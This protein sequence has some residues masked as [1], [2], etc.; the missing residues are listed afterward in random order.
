MKTYIRKSLNFEAQL[1]PPTLNCWAHSIK[2]Q[3]LCEKTQ[4]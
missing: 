4:F 1:A 3:V 2:V